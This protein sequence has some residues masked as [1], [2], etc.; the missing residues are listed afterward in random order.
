MV[1]LQSINNF[2]PDL[3]SCFGE[4]NLPK[5]VDMGAQGTAQVTITNKG[6]KKFPVIYLR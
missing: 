5:T 6:K 2:I 4:I 1:N 3:E